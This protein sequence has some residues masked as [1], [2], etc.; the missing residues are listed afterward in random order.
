M[1]STVA[2]VFQPSKVYAWIQVGEVATDFNDSVTS[3]TVLNTIFD[4][5][6]DSV[7]HRLVN[8]MDVLIGTEI[9]K[10]SGISS[11]TDTGI[12]IARAEL[13]NSLIADRA[14][15]RGAA[16]ASHSDGDAI[17]AWSELN[18]QNGLPLL[19]HLSLEDTLYQPQTL[20]LILRNTSRANIYTDFGILDGVIRENTPLKVIDGSN[21]SVLFRGDVSTISKTHDNNG[22]VLNVT[23]YDALYQLGRSRITGE[24]S[25]VYY[26]SAEAASG[27]GVSFTG[28][29]ATT[30]P[31]VTDKRMS[32][33]IKKLVKNFQPD[34]GDGTEG[35]EKQITM[36]EPVDNSGNAESRF[37]TSD[38]EKTG[39]PIN[40]RINFASTQD[41]VL[42]TLQRLALT[43]INPD[44]NTFGYSF[45][46]DANNYSPSTGLK[47][48]PLL[49]YGATSYLPGSEA[50]ES[51]G[52]GTGEITFQN[53]S[54]T[55]AVT[56]KGSV[57]R[58]IQGAAFDEVGS[59]NVNIINVRYRDSQ[60]G[61][62]REIEME[63][64][65][66]GTGGAY[67]DEHFFQSYNPSSSSDVNKRIHASAGD[68]TGEHGAH[69]DRV[70]YDSAAAKSQSSFPTRVVDAND[71]IIGYVQF[72]GF[73]SGTA[74][75]LVLSGTTNTTEDGNRA[76][77]SAGQTIYLD[78]ASS[79]NTKVL[80]AVTDPTKAN[81]FRPSVATGKRVAITMEFGNDYSF[82]NIREAVAARFL[83]ANNPKVRGRFQVTGA[84]PA[85]QFQSQVAASGDTITETTVGSRTL[86][87]FTD[88]SAASSGVVDSDNNVTNSGY[89]DLVKA[90]SSIMKLDGDG[91][92]V[93]EHGYVNYVRKNNASGQENLRFMLNSGS[94]S[95][96]DYLRF[97]CP[98]RASFMVKVD[99]KMHGISGR[100]SLVTS[101]I[102]NET[103]GKA[104]TD[105]ETIAFRDG[106]I[107]TDG[108]LDIQKAIAARRPNTSNI[109]DMTDD[110]Y[111]G[112]YTFSNYKPHWRGQFF[113]G[114]TTGT[115]SSSSAS[116]TNRAVSWNAGTLYVNGQTFAISKG[117]TRTSGT[118]LGARETAGLFDATDSDND[119]NPDKHYIV[120]FDPHV[121]P[122][123]FCTRSEHEYEERNAKAGRDVIQAD[124]DDLY[125]ISSEN[126]KIARVSASP[127]GATAKIELFVSQGA[128]TAGEASASA[129]TIVYAT[130][131]L[132]GSQL[133]GDVANNWIPS[134][135]DTHNL[136]QSSSANRWDDIFATSGTVN[137]S[138]ERMKEQIKSLN[139]GLDFVK[140]LKPVSYKWKKKKTHKP[141]QT[142]FGIIAQDVVALFDKYNIDSLLD[143]GGLRRDPVIDE[144]NPNNNHDGYYG[145]RYTEFVA[146]LIKA[147]QELSDK[148]DK[149]E[150]EGK[151]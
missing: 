119:G 11:S 63:A 147:I 17:Y 83:A 50:D 46:M 55:S 49:N 30:A 10:V 36:A 127:T 74:G 60:T 61:Q 123:E 34:I 105:I 29:I 13:N 138:D 116:D 109:D 90:G 53:V 67:N 128:P 1:A 108:T 80:S 120:F 151:E 89:N 92:N 114:H 22:S 110:D 19:Q 107:K 12:D 26:G 135:D 94:I 117:D 48:V 106:T 3:M 112:S 101:M 93:S 43:D 16:A 103:A 14:A 77:V 39:S 75:L 69:D 132:G 38:S 131:R 7:G 73:S 121:S 58:M 35:A 87:Q 44:V 97:A 115:D 47:T 142:H 5:E 96:N 59:E 37:R 42:H 18:D 140:D 130:G 28:S 141:D 134:V 57:R 86:V 95:A 40:A 27:G 32:S 6:S 70:H 51:G 124:T 139:L 146:I 72:A 148:V 52:A 31:S 23:A 2:P 118:G 145:A 4:G 9:L 126:L 20:Q 137:A 68:P 122:T 62:M 91:G 113:V 85:I 76:T 78:T 111:G 25:E 24:G 144:K 54:S 136:G 41:S 45:F 79:G 104:Y 150:N 66:V 33:L 98:I 129:S 102:Y 82:A 99:S 125:P 64:F 71:D 149:L 21:F 56:E 8:G 100:P 81:T 143:F 15:D 133:S 88:A 65:Y 84:Y